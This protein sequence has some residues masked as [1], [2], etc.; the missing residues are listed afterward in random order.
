MKTIATVVI[1]AH[2]R[3]EL[4]DRAISSVVRLDK[5]NVTEVIVVDD[6]SFPPIFLKSSRPQDK[7]IRLDKNSGAAVARNVG[8]NN[9]S[10]VNVYLLD[11]DD[12]FEKRNFEEDA[13][14]IQKNVIYFCDIAS[15]SYKSNF[16]DS[17][18]KENFFEY[19][20]CK[21]KFVCQT[22]SLVFKKS[23][24]IFFDESLPKHQD[25][26]LIYSAILRGVE[27]KKIPGQIYF[28]RGDKKSLSRAKN[29][30]ASIFWMEKL[31]NSVKDKN[32]INYIHY[33]IFCRS[34]DVS[35]VSFLW[36]SIVFVFLRKL[37]TIDFLKNFYVKLSV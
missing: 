28:D 23:S 19:I 20:F 15:G 5:N 32:K 26:D 14:I 10:G 30:G 25:W 36:Y 11:S 17:V 34:R 37:K 4:V 13:K 3:Q 16:P 22:S 33:N 12:F 9:A 8:I 27:I 2:N 29:Y 31:K 7:I 21:H 18:S 6:C 24:D 1:P 35:W